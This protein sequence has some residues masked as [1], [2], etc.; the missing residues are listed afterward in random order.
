MEYVEAS[1]PTM[2]A[3][4][5]VMVFYIAGITWS[6]RLANAES[7]M[8]Q[9]SLGVVDFIPGPL[10]NVSTSVMLLIVNALAIASLRTA[11]GSP[12]SVITKLAAVGL[13]AGV[14]ISLFIARRCASK[15]ERVEATLWCLL[16]GPTTVIGSVALLAIMAFSN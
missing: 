11:I 3:A 14:V 2:I 8:Y 5:L 6:F 13:L 1:T 9:E 16:L 10:G 7:E 4:I 15:K 12:W